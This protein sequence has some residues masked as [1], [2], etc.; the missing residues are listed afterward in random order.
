MVHA[1]YPRH[2]G[3][4]H[5]APT[6]PAQLADLITAASNPQLA[7]RSQAPVPVAMERRVIREVGVLFGFEPAS[8]RSRTSPVDPA[9]TCMWTRPGRFHTRPADIDRLLALLDRERRAA[10]S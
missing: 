1:G 7:A 3:L 8:R 10:H 9:S 5:P 4:F 2:F 6:F